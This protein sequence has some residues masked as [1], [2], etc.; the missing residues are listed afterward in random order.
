MKEV[1]KQEQWTEEMRKAVWNV[2]Y[3]TD[4]LHK[5]NLVVKILED[6]KIE[7]EKEV[8]CGNSPS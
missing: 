6:A 7:M 4:G 1:T 2:E 5:A 3:H 8:T